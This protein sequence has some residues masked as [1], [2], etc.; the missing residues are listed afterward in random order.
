VERGI[1]AALPQQALALG[2]ISLPSSSTPQ[3][4]KAP[5]L[6]DF[7][8]AGIIYIV[9]IMAA[10]GAGGWRLVFRVLCVLCSLLLW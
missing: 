1:S 9:V 8:L 6:S 7:F 5:L 4:L 10:G 2:C 3:F